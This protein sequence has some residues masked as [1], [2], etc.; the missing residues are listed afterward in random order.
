MKE[1][2]TQSELEQFT[3][4]EFWYKHA[5]SGYTYTDGIKYLAEKAQA[6]WLL[7]KILI[8]TRAK[9]KLQEWGSWTL[10]CYAD[11]TA[12][13][14]CEDGNGNKLYVAK[15]DYTD[16]PLKIVTLWF[17]NNTLFLPSEN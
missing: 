10:C 8:T 13:L 7:D 17:T 4:T 6:Y 3:G 11:N 14:Q 9:K 5:L 2:L 12:S 16:F 15:I 1:L